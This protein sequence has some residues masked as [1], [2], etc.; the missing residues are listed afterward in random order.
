[1]SETENVPINTSEKKSVPKRPVQLLIFLA[2]IA[3]LAYLGLSGRFGTFSEVLGVL[4][5]IMLVIVGFGMVIMIHEFGHFIVAK[6]SGIKCEAFSIGFPPTILGFRKTENGLR[7]R[8]LPK[9]FPNGTGNDDDD[10][11]IYTLPMKCSESDTEYRIGL[12]PFGGFVKMLGQ[13]DTAAVEV[14]DDPRSFANKPVSTRIGVVAAG[15]IFNAISAVMIF[16]IVFLIGVDLIPAVVGSVRPNSPAQIAG[17][18]PKDRIVE[19]NGEKFVDFLSFSMETMLSGKGE[20][21][22]LKVQHEDGSVEEIEVIAEQSEGSLLPGRGLGIGQ[23]STLSIAKGLSGSNVKILYETTGFK[24]GDTVKTFNGEEVRDAWHL[25]ELVEKALRGDCVLT[26]ERTDPETNKKTLI[27]VKQELL[28]NHVNDNFKTGYDLANVYSM[29]PRLKII[30]VPGKADLE[31][32]WYGKIRSLWKSKSDEQSPEEVTSGPSLEVGDVIIRTADIEYPTYTELREITVAHADKP[33]EFTV[34][35]TDDIGRETLVEVTAVPKR[36]L[37]SDRVQI[38]ILLALDAEHPVVAKTVD[39]K[40]GPSALAIPPGATITAVD[41]KEVSNFYDIMHIIRNNRG[42][43]I[44][45][46]YITSDGSDAG[47]TGISVPLSH[48]Y[49]SAKTSF[50]NAVPF[51]YLKETYKAGSASE[52]VVMGLKKTRMF[53]VNSWL[54]LKRLATREVGPKAV[55]GP[56]GIVT[57]SY[58]IA[59]SQSLTYYLYFLGLISSCIA[60]MNLLPLPVVDGG[61]IV[62]LIIEKIKGSPISQKVQEVISFAGLAFIIA[63]FIF[64]TYNDIVNMFL[65]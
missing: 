51:D 9:M 4:G 37:G 60:V 31:N 5:N 29:I 12:I 39:I 59:K 48:D 24:P 25:D 17:I 34:L 49:I 19:I 16:M 40:N 6:L 43:H 11:L 28:V 63:L 1:M 52:A 56:V 35:R 18:R 57:I 53:I 32:T 62:L 38:G 41:G 14:T 61:V 46:D 47:G 27:T 22:Y 20:S 64:L 54:T 50:A 30:S 23:A 8:I 33:L 15:V 26:V 36:P 7:F 42:Q 21:I 10:G 55:S 3:S 58:K 44:S 13:E 45:I 2:V 65:R